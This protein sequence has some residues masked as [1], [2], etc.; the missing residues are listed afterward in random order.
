MVPSME[1]GN[2]AVSRRRLDGAGSAGVGSTEPARSGGAGFAGAGAGV[3][4]GARLAGAGAG[5]SDYVFTM[6]RADKF[7]GPDR[8]V[9][10][11]ISL[12]VP[13][14]RED[15][16]A[17]AERRRQ[18]DAAADHGRARG[19]VERRSP[20]SRPAR[21]SGCSSRSPSSTRRRT[22]AS[23]VE[24]GVRELRDLL[25]RFNAISAQFAEPDADFDA[26]LAEQA[27]VQEQI[28]RARRLVARR[29]ARPRDGRAAAAGG[30]P[31]RDDALGRR[32]PPGRAL[33]A[34]AL[35]RPTCCCSTS[36]RTTST[37]SRSPGSSASSPTT[38]APS[39][40]S[41]TTA[42]SSTT[43][44]AGSSSSTAAR[45]IP[46]EGNYSSWLE[47][48]QARLAVEEKTESARRPHARARARVGAHEPARA[49][50]EVE[51]APRPPTRSCSPR[52]RT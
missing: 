16:R 3:S 13:A 17:R 40:R 20:S 5:L 19:A 25:D 8:Q 12:V 50:R 21:R 22:C 47:Q 43:S 36:R 44:P 32:A 46:F 33:P 45:G 30:R 37:P 38:R 7:Y 41:P 39:S 35:R 18:V 6:Y 27:T 51:G 14:G 48:K 31:R 23:N 1:P 42:T 29:D 10:A 2:A 34:A 28:D 9:L 49:A 4:G 15:R 26:L 24:D 11:N 52:S